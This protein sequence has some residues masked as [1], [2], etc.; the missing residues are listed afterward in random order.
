MVADSSPLT[1]SSD[2]VEAA[3]LRALEIATKQGNCDAIRSVAVELKARRLERAGVVP[4]KSK[5]KGACGPR[6]PRKRVSLA[7]CKQRKAN[8]HE[9]TSHELILQLCSSRSRWCK[10][11]VARARERR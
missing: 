10:V 4:I 5:V 7:A 6:G 1:G 3:L 9:K 2:V 11:S 8:D